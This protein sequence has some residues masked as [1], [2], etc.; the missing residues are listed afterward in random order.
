MQVSFAS[1]C[2]TYIRLREGHIYGGH[3][4]LQSSLELVPADESQ[5]QHLPS[6]NC[7]LRRS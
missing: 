2:I 7:R 5:D 6:S 3:H 4:S 1:V